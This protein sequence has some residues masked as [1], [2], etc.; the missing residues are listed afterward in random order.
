MRSSY[1]ASTLFQ[2]KII[3]KMR[4]ELIEKTLEYYGTMLGVKGLFSSRGIR[5]CSFHVH[6][7]I[8][9]LMTQL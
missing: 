2:K 9:S 3:E 1:K 5:D 6:A 8:C 7:S 4:E